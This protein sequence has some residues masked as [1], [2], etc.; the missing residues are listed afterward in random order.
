MR[1]RAVMVVM[2]VC[3]FRTIKYEGPPARGEVVANLAMS[4]TI[5]FLPLTIAAVGRALWASY[6]I[7]DKRVSIMSTSPLRTVR[8]REDA[9]SPIPTLPH[10][11][12]LTR[13][14]T[15][16]GTRTCSCPRSFPRTLFM[17]LDS[18]L[19]RLSHRHHQPPST[20]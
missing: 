10:S 4:W 16:T 3:P 1:A 20:I 19:A 11:P 2:S 9:D 17:R 15:R 13:T 18:S 8:T 6:K 14:R 5:V 12:I 7:T